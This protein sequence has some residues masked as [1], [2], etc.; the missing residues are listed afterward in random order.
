MFSSYFSKP[1][2]EKTEREKNVLTPFYEDIVPPKMRKKGEPLSY[3]QTISRAYTHEQALKF[4]TASLEWKNL[5]YTQFPNKPR[6]KAYPVTCCQGVRDTYAFYRVIAEKKYGYIATACHVNI[7]GTHRGDLRFIEINDRTVARENGGTSVIG[8]LYLGD[9]IG[10]SGLARMRDFKAYDVFQ[11]AMDGECIWM[12]TQIQ[13]FPRITLTDVAFSV[14]ANGTAVVKEQSEVMNVLNPTSFPLVPG[15]M[16]TGTA[17]VPEK[18]FSNF[19]LEH[20]AEHKNSLIYKC[21]RI[22]QYPN[23]LGT[24]YD[25]K[26]SPRLTDAFSIG[27]DAFDIDTTSIYSENTPTEIMETCVL[28][29]YAAANSITNGRFDSRSFPMHNLSRDRTVV[30]FSIDNPAEDP[31]EGKWMINSR[32]KI[33]GPAG[34][35]N[36]TIETV[37]S[38]RKSLKITARLSRDIPNHVKFNNG[39]HVVYQREAME[40]QVLRTGLSNKAPPGSN[41]RQILEVLYGAEPLEC[42]YNVNGTSYFFPDKDPVELNEYQCDYVDMILA[43]L[44]IVVGCSP[45]GCG[46]SM[47]IVT[48]ALEIHKRSVARRNKFYTLEKKKV[49]LLVTQSNY[50]SVNLVDIAN[51][52]KKGTDSEGSKLKFVRYLSEK[53][54]KELADDCLTDYDLPKLMEIESLAWTLGHRKHEKLEF[55]HMASMVN[56]VIEGKIARPHEFVGQAMSTY[57]NSAFDNFKSWPRDLLEAFFML[58]DPDLIMTTADSLQTLLSSAI[59]IPSSVETIQIDEASQVPEYTFISLLTSFPNASYGLI[60]DIEQLPP[61][62]ETGLDGKLKDY[63]IGNTMERAVNGEMFPQAML[64]EVYRCSPRITNLLSDLFYEGQLISGVTVDQ[65]N[66]FVRKRK[67]FWPKSEFPVLVLNNKE[68]G[69]KM[70]TSCGNKSEKEIV[71]ALL[72]LLTKEHNRYKLKPSDIGVISFYAAQTSILTEALRG[73]GVKC[74][75]VDAFQGSEKEVIILCCT[76]EKISDFMQ[77]SNRINVAMSRGRQ[78]TIIIGNV[79][80]LK[81]ADYWSVIVRAAEVEGCVMD[82]NFLGITQ[83]S[84]PQFSKGRNQKERTPE[85]VAAVTNPTARGRGRRGRQRG[86]GNP[87]EKL[88]DED[89][90]STSNQ[91][92]NNGRNNRNRRRNNKA[93]PLEDAGDIPSASTQQAQP[94]QQQSKR[95]N[96]AGWRRRNNKKESPA[97]GLESDRMVAWKIPQSTLHYEFSTQ[98]TNLHHQSGQINRRQPD[99]VQQLGAL[100][101]TVVDGLAYGIVSLYTFFTRPRPE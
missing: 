4:A 7:H 64:R 9:M 43:K 14:L 20:R 2:V 65:R 41:G 75:T 32:I 24:V 98:P 63:G 82:T 30:R 74:G 80:G 16:Y 94:S 48:A 6:T 61:Y 37:I 55:R 93:K 56:F 31:T 45:F 77:M 79:D 51:K 53:N 100:C 17:F 10:V 47:T 42:D 35:L 59:L 62:C 83:T 60:G 70:G 68:K 8:R 91:Q 26:E 54:W 96:G 88:I 101:L 67:D 19:T 34:E 1:A 52:A 23:S 89:L 71:N 73:R 11:S 87:Q 81:K 86:N 90:P 76:N 78:A 95:D 27:V 85:G 18:M 12:A 39:I 66:E 57:N 33:S 84:R 99:I 97:G 22:H 38:E 49:Q 92:A 21:S 50:A 15:K 72:N 69:Y 46:K 36:A 3:F 29:G 58:Y 5:V 40:L 28:M 13:V 44:P 25:F